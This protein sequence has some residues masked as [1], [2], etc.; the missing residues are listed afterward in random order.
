MRGLFVYADSCSIHGLPI[1]R[2]RVAC[3]PRDTPQRLEAALFRARE[4]EN[5]MRL[6]LQ[7]QSLYD[8]AKMFCEEGDWF[9]EQ[10]YLAMVMSPDYYSDSVMSDEE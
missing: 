8:D 4:E 1:P 2:Q 5:H 9:K 6:R 10:Q 7:R 3:I